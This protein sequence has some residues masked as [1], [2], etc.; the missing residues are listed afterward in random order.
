M[1]VVSV[2]RRQDRNAAKGLS[3]LPM[4][5]TQESRTTEGS[6]IGGALLVKLRPPACVVGS[7]ESAWPRAEPGQGEQS[8][9]HGR[10]FKFLEEVTGRH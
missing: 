9:E 10:G 5:Q 7:K 4:I 1:W 8:H 2:R 3:A 6:Q